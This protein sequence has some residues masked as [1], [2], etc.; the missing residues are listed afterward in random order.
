[1]STVIKTTFCVRILMYQICMFY[2]RIFSDR[3][4]FCLASLT[5]VWQLENLVI[6]GLQLSEDFD[7]CNAGVSIKF[8]VGSWFE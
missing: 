3:I 7:V 6:L 8:E 1:M 5:L 2:L 4:A